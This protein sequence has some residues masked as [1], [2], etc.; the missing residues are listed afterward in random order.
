MKG[1][2]IIVEF[3]LFFVISF[4]LFI[5]ISFIF[6]NQ[7]VNLNQKIGDSLLDSVNSLVTT[8][9]IR[10]VGCG[11]CDNITMKETTPARLG[12]FF[13]IISLNKQ[14]LNNT[15]LSE[16]SISKTSLIFNLNE[17]YNQTGQTKGENKIVEITINNIRRTISV[18]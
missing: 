4:S 5:T 7:N 13:Y 2:T 16:K 18:K 6:Y 1:Q 15:M 17:T 8:N 11:G 9:I 3:I 12:G 14:N 10:G